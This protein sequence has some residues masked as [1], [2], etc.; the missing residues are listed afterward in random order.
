MILLL[1]I[2]CKDGKTK[3]E[4]GVEYVASTLTIFVVLVP[5]IHNICNEQMY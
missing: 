5:S 2:T 3:E 1:S 4:F